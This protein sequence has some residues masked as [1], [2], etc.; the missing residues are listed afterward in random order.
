MLLVTTLERTRRGAGCSLS[1]TEEL[2]GAP[3]VRL[4]ATTAS[5]PRS[6][7][8]A[9][10]LAL[11][12]SFARSALRR[13]RTSAW[14][15]CALAAPSRPLLPLGVATSSRLSGGL[16]LPRLRPPLPSPLTSL[17]SLSLLSL[18]SLPLLLLLLLLLSSELEESLEEEPDPEDEL[19]SEE[20]EE[21][22]YTQSAWY[23]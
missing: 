3:C 1:A 11:R 18:L 5:T 14:A 19:S 10:G 13:T 17:L 4:R 9:L 21:S 2:A 22:A 7:P 16:R 8:A 15:S 6:L 20:D 23:T 12:S